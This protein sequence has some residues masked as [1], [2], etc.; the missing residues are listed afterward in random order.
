MLTTLFPSGET[1]N[2]KK[3]DSMST[4]QE[5]ENSSNDSNVGHREQSVQRVVV[6]MEHGTVVSLRNLVKGRVLPNGGGHMVVMTQ[7]RL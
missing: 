3:S 6:Y 4:S 2:A 1:F 7:L 5:R